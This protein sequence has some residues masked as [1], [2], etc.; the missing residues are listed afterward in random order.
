M[1]R[2][3]S[4]AASTGFISSET[5]LGMIW[6]VMAGMVVLLIGNPVASAEQTATESVKST[7][8][9]VIHILNS[10][11]LKQPGRS[12]ERRQKIEQVIRQRV[13]YE[14]MAKR[15]LGWPWIELTNSERQEFV[16]LFVQL[17]RDTFA[18]RIDNYADEQVLYLS[19]QREENVAEVKAKLSG[20]KVD[21][22]LDFRLADKVGHW[23]VYD[24]IIDGAGIVG[25]YRAQ[26]ASIIRDHSYAGLVNKMKEKTLVVKAFETTTDP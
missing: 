7:I 17:L 18:C 8:D 24:V 5:R 22:L 23:Y 16:A 15:A 14:D 6:G 1:N 2:I 21:T 12:V 9:E 10:E 19:E 26:F 20:L 13:S 11:E 3:S 4:S 25:N